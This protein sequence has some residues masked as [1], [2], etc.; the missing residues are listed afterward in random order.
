M[1]LNCL[2]R[3]KQNIFPALTSVDNCHCLHM[4]KPLN[5]LLNVLDH[6]LL[7]VLDILLLNVLDLLLHVLEFLLLDLPMFLIFFFLFL[8]FFFMI[9]IFPFA[10]SFFNLLDLL[11]IRS[12]TV[13]PVSS[14]T[15]SATLQQGTNYALYIKV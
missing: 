10:V 12:Q 13:I 15:W 11:L 5:L 6:L 7:N 14:R 9:F 1:Q 8:I 4:K 3:V 2:Q